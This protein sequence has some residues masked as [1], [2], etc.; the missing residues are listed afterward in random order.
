VLQARKAEVSPNESVRQC[1]AYRDLHNTLRDA[2]LID[3][4][5]PLEEVARAVEDV[6]LDYMARRMQR[7]LNLGR[8]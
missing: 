8:L 1:R 2:H 6:I 4:S 7:R 5:R 3:A